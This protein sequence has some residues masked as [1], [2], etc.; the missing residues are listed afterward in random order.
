MHPNPNSESVDGSFFEYSCNFLQKRQ[1][2]SSHLKEV[3]GPDIDAYFLLP[4]YTRNDILSC[5]KP[6]I[7]GLFEDT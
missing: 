3:G 2:T 7:P 4:T 6:H 5:D 1:E